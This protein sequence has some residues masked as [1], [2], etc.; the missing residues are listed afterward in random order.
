MSGRDVGNAVA[1]LLALVILVGCGLF[2]VL[3]CNARGR[4]GTAEIDLEAELALLKTSFD[5]LSQRQA[6]S[7]QRGLVNTN[8]IDQSSSDKWVNR[9]LAIGLVGV[10]LLGLLNYPVQ[11][12]LRIRREMRRVARGSGR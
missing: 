1:V 5:D 8:K 2:L 6:A 11:R 9:A 10:A 7:S 12:K 3:G 4:Q